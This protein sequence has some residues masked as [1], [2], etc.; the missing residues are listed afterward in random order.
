MRERGGDIYR[1]MVTDRDR[2]TDLERL[3][4]NRG[5]VGGGRLVGKQQPL[6]GTAVD[7]RTCILLRGAASTD[8]AQQWSLF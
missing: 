6:G 4:R 5:K 8:S 7:H 3:H 1:E 2:D